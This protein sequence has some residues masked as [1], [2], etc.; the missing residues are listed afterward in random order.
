M[1]T[2]DSWNELKKKI[3]KQE[4]IIFCNKREIW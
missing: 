3:S 1:D 2:F 4:K